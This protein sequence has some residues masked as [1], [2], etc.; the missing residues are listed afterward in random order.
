MRFFNIQETL[1]EAF[2]K[3]ILWI[4]YSKNTTNNTTVLLVLYAEMMENIFFF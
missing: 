2:E 3:N 1:T 4:Q